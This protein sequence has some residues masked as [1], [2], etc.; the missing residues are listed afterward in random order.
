[1]NYG[2]VATVNSRFNERQ[3][4]RTFKEFKRLGITKIRFGG[5]SPLYLDT[6]AEKVAAANEIALAKSL[7]FYTERGCTHLSG[8]DPKLSTSNWTTYHDYALD[9]A[10]RFYAVGCDTFM[11]AN[12]WTASNV[13]GTTIT[14]SDDIY[15]RLVALAGDIH[16]VCPNMKI[17]YNGRAYGGTDGEW[18]IWQDWIN[19]HGALPAYMQLGFNIYGGASFDSIIFQSQVNSVKAI[20]GYISEW[21]LTSQAWVNGYNFS[22]VPH[23]EETQYNVIKERMQMIDSAQIDAFFWNWHYWNINGGEYNW[24]SIIQNNGTSNF[25]DPTT[26]KRPFYYALFPQRRANGDDKAVLFDGNTYGDTNIIP[27]ATG[28]NIGFWYKRSQYF[29]SNEEHVI[30]NVYPGDGN[31]NGFRLYHGPNQKNLIFTTKTSSVQGAFN[32]VDFFGRGRWRY[33]TITI[34]QG[35]AVLWID[36]KPAG[37]FGSGGISGDIGTPTR[38]ITIA[39]RATDYQVKGRVYMQK[40]VIQNTATPWTQKQ[41]LDLMRYNRLPGTPTAYYKFNGNVLD[42]SG[43]NYHLTVPA[44]I[45]YTRCTPGA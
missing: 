40:L 27:A 32:V 10:Q 3:V 36:G 20:N 34:G 7:G 44:N 18:R 22:N 33:I 28:V 6:E 23:N 45:S 21:N 1:M 29:S 5:T 19:A 4:L 31:A 39:A 17:V 30:C 26:E 2:A 11:I 38:P 16:A 43:N 14:Y 37:P 12:E 25:D 24:W 35:K 15:T 9:L 8:V 42:S 41:I 13:D